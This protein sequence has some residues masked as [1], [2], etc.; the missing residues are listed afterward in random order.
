MDISIYVLHS[1][2]FRISWKTLEKSDLNFNFGSYNFPSIIAISNH[3]HKERK[4]P[5][6]IFR[7]KSCVVT[8][9][10]IVEKICEGK[11]I[12]IKTSDDS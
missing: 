3:S 2:D 12:L 10:N 6:G 4:Q 9:I 5:Q 1:K 11:F 7:Q 8:L